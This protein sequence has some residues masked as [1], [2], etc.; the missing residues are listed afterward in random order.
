[1][2]SIPPEVKQMLIDMHNHTITSSPD[3]LLSPEELVETARLRG[4]DAVCVTE[5]YYLE[6]ASIAQEVGRKL[7]FPVF[8]GIEAST[9]HGHL[10]VFGYY[11]DIPEYMAFDELCQRVHR[12]GGVL[13]AAH[14]YRLDG[15]GIMQRGMNLSQGLLSTL[16]ELD[17]LEV[18]NGKEEFAINY[19]A[20]KLAGRLS[21][22]GIG[23]SDSHA[24]EQV[25]KAAT[26]FFHPIRS[27]EELV[28]ALKTSGYQA[29]NNNNFLDSLSVN[30]MFFAGIPG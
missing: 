26:E 10:L 22:P 23:G 17:G 3:S 1:M 2:R 20:C 24:I 28:A 5:H 6:G 30:E 9:D 7:N 4:L 8:R 11:E 18:I 27:D 14:P 15:M 21:L 12:A 25:A 19:K 16:R 29:V 13:F